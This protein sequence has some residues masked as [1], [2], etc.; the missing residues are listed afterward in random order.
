MT[1]ENTMGVQTGMVMADGKRPLMKATTR[2]DYLSK[3]LVV[4]KEHVR[5]RIYAIILG[6]IGAYL[7][8]I[9]NQAFAGILSLSGAAYFYQLHKHREGRT[10]KSNRTVIIGA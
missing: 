2:W 3:Q 9:A 10:V 1:Y 8:F 5:F 4:W 7:L 6:A